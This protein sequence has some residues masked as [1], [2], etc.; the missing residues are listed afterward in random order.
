MEAFLSQAWREKSLVLLMADAVPQ[1]E[2]RT[3]RRLGNS[4]G[5][6]TLRPRHP[7]NLVGF[8]YSTLCS[9]SQKLNNTHVNLDGEPVDRRLT[10][11]R[12]AVDQTSICG[13][14]HQPLLHCCRVEQI[15]LLGHH[16]E[17]SLNRITAPVRHA[18]RQ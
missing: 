6:C 14:S 13:S 16:R 11:A 15:W 17:R 9:R 3:P 7:G 2:R 10:L 1:T 12:V 5:L 8:S 4:C 18:G